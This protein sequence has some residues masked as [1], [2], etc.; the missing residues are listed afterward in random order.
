MTD[1]DGFGAYFED[2]G[3]FDWGF[4]DVE[5]PTDSD[6]EAGDG[7]IERKFSQHSV[8][9]VSDGEG[10]SFGEADDQA[11]EAYEEELLAAYLR[12]RSVYN[13]SKQQ[14]KKLTFDRYRDLLDEAIR[15][16][17]HARI[18]PGTGYI[19]ARPDPVV[20]EPA[21]L[22]AFR[23]SSPRFFVE[24]L[25]TTPLSTQPTSEQTSVTNAVTVEYPL[26]LPDASAEVVDFSSD[27]SSTSTTSEQTSVTNAVTVEYPLFLPDASAE[28]IDFSSTHLSSPNG[29]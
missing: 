27:H 8:P 3:D 7:Q 6:S 14:L 18:S 4:D 15:Q 12:F 17:L 28:V 19:N 5:T 25:S 26:F 1:D 22:E 9:N 23:L 20:L 13:G 16:V 2:Y 24:N 21:H 11:L 10:D 29:Y